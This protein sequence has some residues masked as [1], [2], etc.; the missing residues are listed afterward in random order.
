MAEKGFGI[1]Q[2]DIIGST[3]TPLV[4]SKIGLNIRL[5][6]QGTGGIG[7][8]VGIGTTGLATW[9]TTKNNADPDNVT[10]LNCGIIT[11]NYVYGTF[12]GIID[13]ITSTITL[14]SNIQDVLSVAANQISADDAGADKIVFWDDDPG[15]LTHLAV[16][17]GLQI[18]GTTLSATAD[19]GKTYTLE[20]VD[21][22]ANAILRL[23]DGTTDD[24]VT[25]TA[26]TNITIDPVAVDG[27]TISAVQG[28][29]LAL[30]ATVTDVLD[31]SSGTLSADDAGAD[32]I[33]FWDDDPGKLTHL[34]VGTGLQI[35]GTTL[36]ATSDAGKT[37]TLESSSS[38]DDVVLT[39]SDGTTDDP[40]TITKGSGIQFSSITAGGFTIAATADAGKT[41]T[42]EGVDSGDNAI[43][44]LS[45]GTTDDDVTIT[46]GAN[47]T[48]NPVTAGGFTIAAVQGA[49][50]ALD[51][52]VTD[53]FNL[54]SGTL[55]ADD[56]GGVAPFDRI[57]FWD[58]SEDKLTHLSLGTGLQISG[59][60]ISATSDAGK[61]YE[62]KCSTDSDGGNTG[63]P[64]D[65]YLFLDASSG[66]DDAVRI[67]G[68]TNI[69]V[70]RDNDGQLTIEASGTATTNEIVQGNTK[71]EVIDTG[72][73][74]HFKVTTEG[75]QRLEVTSSGV[76]E[77]QGDVSILN[78]GGGDNPGV[79]TPKLKFVTPSGNLGEIDAVSEGSGGPHGHGGSLR[80]YTK[81]NNVAAAT[82]RL[83]IT[84]TGAWGIEGASNYGTS[85]QVLTSNGNDSPTWQT[86]TS[87][88]TVTIDDEASSS[89]RDIVYTAGAGSGETLR[90]NDTTGEQ[91]ALQVRASDGAMRVK[92]DITAYR[93]SD[94]TL[95][96]NI[97]PIKNALAKV[98]SISGNTFTWNEKSTDDKRGNDD[99]GVIA[100]E[101]TALGLPG[102][103]TTR[104]D[105]TQA[106]M[107]EKLV[108][109]LIEAIKELKEEVDELKSRS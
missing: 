93:S 18:S 62:L 84:S 4:E 91:S 32:K 78:N 96:D 16:G 26:G 29:G 65:P 67:V 56:P 57:I 47:I 73:N 101:I 6:G 87:A 9:L 76:L 36:S 34:A 24:D 22:G 15:K 5:G 83:C 89:W 31:I 59:S 10:T 63:T 8:T 30:D 97:S 50:L 105:G 55:S 108:P 82:E 35:S 60:T 86:G 81:T 11:A 98:S 2:L 109:L 77:M 106:V 14:N 52:T 43:L 66:S 48:I 53:V 44:R 75:T 17:T 20:G 104:E 61:T 71:A 25:I 103:T 38:S 51:G 64:A 90:C 39:L 95:K 33:V 19:A 88:I 79:T 80:F 107:Y 92:G 69:N 40:V 41:Y 99:T 85:G 3:G 45:D 21:S 37:Y 46:A 13:P 23:S 70:N 28:A 49:G 74:G 42:L 68:G 27:F 102:V 7:H 12:R 58:D 72:S 1:K 100:Q 54:S 94:I